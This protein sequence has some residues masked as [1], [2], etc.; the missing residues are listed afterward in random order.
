MVTKSS[1]DS[2]EPRSAMPN[3]EN[4]YPSRQKVRSDSDEP[5]AT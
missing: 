1:T 5:M 2:A 4:E 3:T